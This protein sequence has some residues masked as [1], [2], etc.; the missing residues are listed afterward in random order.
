LSERAIVLFAHGAADTKWAIPFRKLQQRIREL[1]PDNPVE[2]CFL[3]V[4]PP[5]LL[6]C[7]DRLVAKG[8]T[9]IEVYPL[10]LAPGGHLKNDLPLLLDLVLTHHPQLKIK[11]NPALGEASE[12]LEAIAGWIANN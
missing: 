1:K 11:V 5:S 6:E 3:E 10:F 2:L 4:M 12:L 9:H 7:V 8:I